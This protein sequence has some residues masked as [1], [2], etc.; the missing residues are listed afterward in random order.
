MEQV[1]QITVKDPSAPAS[2]KQK[3]A[4]GLNI[5][6][7]IFPEG[8]TKGEASHIISR[9]KNGERQEAIAELIDK[10]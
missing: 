8:L 9:L 3:Q 7:A 6:D 1:T 2:F 4:I 10:L 5:L